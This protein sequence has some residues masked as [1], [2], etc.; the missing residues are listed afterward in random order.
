MGVGPVDALMNA[1]TLLRSFHESIGNMQIAHGKSKARAR[2]RASQPAGGRKR[3]NRPNSPVYAAGRSDRQILPVGSH[4]QYPLSVRPLRADLR[5]GRRRGSDGTISEPFQPIRRPMADVGRTARTLGLTLAGL[6][7]GLLTVSYALQRRP[8]DLVMGLSP[9]AFGLAL[10]GYFWLANRDRSI[11]KSASLTA[12][13]WA[14]YWLAFIVAGGE[15]TSHPGLSRT[16]S[17]DAVPFLAGGIV[18]SLVMSTATF[19]LYANAQPR[20]WRLLVCT[21]GGCR[22]QKLCAA[23]FPRKSDKQA[24]SGVW[25]RLRFPRLV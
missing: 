2:R 23:G 18:G 3:W 11:L 1:A 19:S 12:I 21:I 22:A 6:V 15:V 17:A 4:A 13:S 20:L 16:G 7:G 10:A 5:C 8:N 24:P 9:S 25:R 14:A